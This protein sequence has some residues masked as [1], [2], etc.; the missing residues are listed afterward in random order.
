MDMRYLYSLSNHLEEEISKSYF[1]RNPIR[2]V[3]R[4]RMLDGGMRVSFEFILRE[5]TKLFDEKAYIEKLKA[6]G[7]A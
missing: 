1:L 7:A 5:K 6:E 4:K 2:I 3:K